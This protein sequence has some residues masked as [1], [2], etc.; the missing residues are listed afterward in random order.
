MNDQPDPYAMPTKLGE[1]TF[2]P[3]QAV[4]IRT[5]ED[6]WRLATLIVKAKMAPSGM[7]T[8][9][10]IT[11]ALLHGAEIGLP[12]MMSVQKIAVIGGRP[13]VWGD[14]ALAVVRNSGLLDDIVEGIE[15]EGDARHAYCRVTRKGFREEE[16][17]FS[18]LD[19]KAAGLWD[20]RPTSRRKARWDMWANGKQIKKDEWYDAPNDAPWKR[21]SDRMLKMRARGYRLRDSFG[22]VLGGLYL[23][24]EF[25]GGQTIEHDPAEKAP[26]RQQVMT[27]PTPPDPPSN[28]H[29]DGGHHHHQGPPAPPAPPSADH[30]KLD[31]VQRARFLGEYAE[32]LS[33]VK[34]EADLDTLW[35]DHVMPQIDSDSLD[36]ETI[37]A[38]KRADDERRGLIQ[39]NGGDRER[40]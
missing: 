11:V 3:S 31:D 17:T 36:N 12:P 4:A 32:R 35:N 27:P 5:M 2:G 40:D 13:T 28:N 16:S 10:Q 18:V 39:T 15:G 14:A 24:E 20:D 9:E 6:A 30:G 37:E 7:D 26:A 29:N 8:V 23:R 25:I 1:L 38:L 22:D 21:F 34:T 19:A 33:D